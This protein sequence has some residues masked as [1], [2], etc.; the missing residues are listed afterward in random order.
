MAYNSSVQSSTNYTLFYLMFG[1]EARLPVDIMYRP[2]EQQDQSYGEYAR[3][4]QTRLHTAFDLVKKNITK[5]HQHQKEFYDRKIHG[6]PY[7]AGDLVWLHSSVPKKKIMP[8]ASLSLDRP[9]QSAETIIRRYLLDPTLA[10][11]PTP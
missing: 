4:L 9:L 7:K 5:E 8:E 6:N 3:L 1:R 10:W 11:K 2:I